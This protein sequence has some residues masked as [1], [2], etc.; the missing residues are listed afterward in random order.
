MELPSFFSCNGFPLLKCNFS[1]VSSA[2]LLGSKR[3]FHSPL[4]FAS[5]LMH[6]H[7]DSLPVTLTEHPLG[8]LRNI[9]SARST[10]HLPQHPDLKNRS[11][12]VPEC[13]SHGKKEPRGK[14]LGGSSYIMA[15]K[16][17]AKMFA[18]AERVRQGEQEALKTGEG[19]LPMTKRQ[20]E[21]KWWPGGLPLRP[22][23][24]QMLLFVPET[25]K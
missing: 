12:L 16:T 18:T 23:S 17:K 5:E 11:C 24:G 15:F 14:G 7:C 6:V 9:Y 2:N 8:S 4:C 20:G 21:A 19:L 10:T 13:S 3:G 22:L 1:T 25:W